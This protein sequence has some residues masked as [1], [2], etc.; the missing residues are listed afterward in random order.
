MQKNKIH[1]FSKYLFS[2]ILF[3]SNGTIAS[4]IALNS[5]QTV[6]LRTLIGSLFLLFL[7]LISGKKFTFYKHKKQFAF[8]AISGMAMGGS[9][10]F[11][12]EAYRRIGVG[13]SSL[14][15]Y[16]GPIIVIALS[17][18]LFKER[19]TVNKIIG[20]IIVFCG[21]VLLN[22]NTFDKSGNTFGVICGLLSAVLYAFMIIFNKKATDIVG[23]ENSLLQ[24]FFAFFTVA[25]FVGITAGYN[26]KIPTESII[27][28]LILGLLN[29][30]VGCYFYFSSI[31]NLKVQT[32]AVCGYL[33]PLSAVMFSAFILKEKLLT[34]QI[35]GI[36]LIING[37]ILCECK[38]KYN[39]KF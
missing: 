39:T 26:F 14:L 13:I 27:P 29:T 32:V 20:F 11:L 31:T 33:E 38:I 19:L 5:R 6:L 37:A 9:W 2:L 4:F 17:P 8:L 7:F 30:G 28:I 1:S 18:I 24:L 35:L 12:Y 10:M 16:C 25:V 3:G 34:M 21:V 22:I 15:Y 23:F 36:F